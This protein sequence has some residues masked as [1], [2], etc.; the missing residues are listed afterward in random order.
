MCHLN[1]P[2]GTFRL[3]SQTLSNVRTMCMGLTQSLVQV[4]VVHSKIGCAQ[5]LFFKLQNE[6]IY[7]SD[8]KNNQQLS[9]FCWSEALTNYGI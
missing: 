3:I 1:E 8:K 4:G 7:F 6:V 9:L 2:N 5:V